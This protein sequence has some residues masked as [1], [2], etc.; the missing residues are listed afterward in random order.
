MKQRHYEL[1]LRS[2]LITFYFGRCIKSQKMGFK[3]GLTDE[4][5]YQNGIA[6]FEVELE[7]AN[8]VIWRKGCITINLHAFIEFVDQQKIPE[9]V[10]ILKYERV[11]LSKTRHALI[12]KNCNYSDFGTYQAQ[13][14]QDVRNCC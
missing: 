2:V 6:R 3:R 14:G 5:S 4:T 7:Y 9:N 12:V 8:N 11:K 13:S 1:A 10:S